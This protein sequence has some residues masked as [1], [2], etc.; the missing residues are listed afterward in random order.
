MET[1]RQTLSFSIIKIL[2][3]DRATCS[4]E[5]EEESPARST[6]TS[7]CSG[8]EEGVPSDCPSC[9]DLELDCRE[10]SGT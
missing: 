1:V 6:I 8:P 10:E 2:G 3:K 9:E 7:S 4:E 5:E